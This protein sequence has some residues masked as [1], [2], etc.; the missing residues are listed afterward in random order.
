MNQLIARA[1]DTSNKSKSL[2]ALK[3]DKNKADDKSANLKSADMKP[4][5]PKPDLKDKNKNKK[6][7][8]DNCD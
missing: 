3:T 5:E 2:K 7:K 6:L 8:K 1:I 4:T